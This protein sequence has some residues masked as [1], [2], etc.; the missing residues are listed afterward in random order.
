VYVIVEGENIENRGPTDSGKQTSSGREI[1]GMLKKK[2]GERGSYKE[3]TILRLKGKENNQEE[4]E[5]GKKSTFATRARSPRDLS[6]S[7]SID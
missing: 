2:R 5:T 7:I 1:N 3:R 6:T 4:N